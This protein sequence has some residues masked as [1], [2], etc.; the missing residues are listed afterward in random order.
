[1]DRSPL[2][3][4]EFVV[5]VDLVAPIACYWRTMAFADSCE[6]ASAC[7]AAGVLRW[8][9]AAS[10]IGGFSRFLPLR[11]GADRVGR[12]ADPLSFRSPH[13]DRDRGCIPG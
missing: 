2:T 10:S 12:F 11:L 13:L 6:S 4:S 5:G 7:W 8:S 1:M 3:I 9:G